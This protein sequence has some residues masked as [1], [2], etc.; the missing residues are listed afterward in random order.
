MTEKRKNKIKFFVNFLK[1]ENAY[2]KF[3]NN[4]L[5][6]KGYEIYYTYLKNYFSEYSIFSAFTWVDTKEGYSYWLKL[7]EKFVKKYIKKYKN[8]N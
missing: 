7:N 2:G 6:Q 3:K 8:D 4:L 5:K 1:E